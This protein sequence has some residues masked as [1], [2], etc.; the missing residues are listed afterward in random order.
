[1]SAVRDD[2]DALTSHTGPVGRR[3]QLGGQIGQRVHHKG[4]LP[5]ARVGQGQARAV[6]AGMAVHEQVQV[7][8][9]RRVGV[10]PQ[11]AS[12]GEDLPEAFKAFVII[13]IDSNTFWLLSKLLT[14]LSATCDVTR[15]VQ[16]S[17]KTLSSPHTPS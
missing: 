7:Q 8:G 17:C 9:A 1:M 2:L 12:R 10:R 13:S 3:D 11:T 6:H 5:K 4:P 15:D 14:S 16:R